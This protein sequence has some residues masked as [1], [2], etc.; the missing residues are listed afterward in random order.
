MRKYDD[1]VE[2]S[3]DTA[4]NKMFIQHLHNKHD[5]IKCCNFIR[6]LTKAKE[7]LA[8]MINAN[9][10]FSYKLKY[11]NEQDVIKRYE[12]TK[13]IQSKY[14]YKLRNSQRK[15]L[16]LSLNSKINSENETKST[17]TAH[18]T[19]I[20]S[21]TN[22][23]NQSVPLKRKQIIKRN[24]SFSKPYEIEFFS[25]LS[26]IYNNNTNNNCSSQETNNQNV[27]ASLPVV[28][29]QSLEQNQP[30]LM[31]DN[32]NLKRRRNGGML[33]S[34]SQL[35]CFVDSIQQD[36]LKRKNDKSFSLS[37][38]P[39]VNSHCKPFSAFQT[40]YLKC[41][42]H[43]RSSQEIDNYFSQ[44][45]IMDS[46]HSKN[47]NKSFNENIQQ[48]QNNLLIDNSVHQ[49][50]TNI[51]NLINMKSNTTK[52]K[53]INR[54]NR[55]K[56]RIQKLDVIAKLSENLAFKNR[57]SYLHEFKFDYD[58][59]KDFIFHKDSNNIRPYN[60]ND[61]PQHIRKYE[62]NSYGRNNH[63]NKSIEQILNE[64]EKDKALL[65]KRIESS[66]K[67]YQKE[68]RYFMKLK[69]RFDKSTNSST[70]IDVMK[71]T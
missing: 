22:T 55:M 45:K 48:I 19:N 21:K 34:S 39:S 59:D 64:T 14:L 9:E 10:Y 58:D 70:Y 50:N 37:Q 66:Q 35:N 62:R 8:N 42:T 67:K 63:N 5:N 44:K 16:N 30:V 54:K 11:P 65:I 36:S 26:K 49:S 40:I 13:S 25:G 6:L 43:I 23:K 4:M 69:K 51:I 3:Y 68:K 7:N 2:Q 28:M 31:F 17:T 47:R 15:M 52:L 32:K 56:E 71:K 29:K 46:F 53:E 20:R 60:Y 41:D 57:C 27:N 38:S 18:N 33:R 61:K 1:E 24:S 12:H